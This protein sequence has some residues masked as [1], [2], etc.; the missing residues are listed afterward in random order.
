MID[1]VF[2][3]NN[4]KEFISI[5]EK[6]NIKHLI[7]AYKEP[8]DISSFQHKP[9]VK[10]SQAILCTPDNI[11]KYKGR[12]LTL[13]Q[14]PS[15]QT[16]LRHIIESAKPDILFNLE[17]ASRPDFMHH[18]ASGLNHV[19]AAIAKQKNVTI[20]FS[21][22]AILTAKPSQRAVCLGRMM[23]NIRFARKFGFKTIIAS[24][25]QDPMHMRA[26]QE[27]AS[28]FTT[29]GMTSGECKKALAWEVPR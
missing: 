24:F 26:A 1:I 13:I 21:F 12:F 10:V 23:Q 16:K 28:I 3:N 18:R 27:L 20:G 9:P 25:A 8:K 2:P 17:L 5:A 22:S 4:E 19:L 15:D 29:L 14:A 7:F 6:L 11:R